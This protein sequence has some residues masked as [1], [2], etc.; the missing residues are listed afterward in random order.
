MSFE[1][2]QIFFTRALG[3]ARI[4]AVR[5]DHQPLGIRGKEIDEVSSRRARN[6]DHPPCAP[7]GGSDHQPQIESR[8]VGPI[9]WRVKELNEIM[10]RHNHRAREELWRHVV[11]EMD[12][13]HV[14]PPQRR[15]DLDMLGNAV[16]TG[17]RRD[18]A[19]TRS[20]RRTRSS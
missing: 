5:N 10:H 17:G 15:W 13:I 9:A 18:D 20:E 14:F 12:Q 8:Q 7:E 11:G 19:S 6:G 16:T 1:V 2:L 4:D 3:D